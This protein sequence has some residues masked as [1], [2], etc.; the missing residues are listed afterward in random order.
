MLVI[1]I[2]IF[3]PIVKTYAFYRKIGN[4]QIE[5]LEESIMIW[6]ALRNIE[7]KIKVKNL[8]TLRFDEKTWFLLEKCKEETNVGE[9]Y[10]IEEAIKRYLDAYENKSEVF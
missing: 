5:L 4:E 8:T 10:I 6:E 7:E 2:I 3:F 9:N 1:E